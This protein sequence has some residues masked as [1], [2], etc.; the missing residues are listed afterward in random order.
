MRTLAFALFLTVA[1]PL[2][3]TAQMSP[4]PPTDRFSLTA[5]TGARVPFTSGSVVV[6]GADGEALFSAS[7]QR[8]GN[9]VL[10]VE[11]EARVWRNLSLLVGGLYSRTGT[12][13]F[14]VDRDPSYVERGDYRVRY[15][16]DTWFA[17]AGAS[18][19]FSGESRVR[20]GRPMPS[21]DLFAAGAVLREF[22]ASHPA[23][24]VGFRGSFPAGR[25]VEASVGLEDYFVFWDEAALAPAMLDVLGP[26]DP[27]SSSARLLYDTSHLLVL[28]VGA[29]LRF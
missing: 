2:A 23:V 29:T 5:Y 6:Y 22:E 20:D 1:V 10:G 11:G 9:P 7:E 13:E 28:R 17:K 24:N 12:G 25:G 8:G 14:Y 15:L 4:P 19:K 26:A 21:T 18:V 3:S 27:A 16:T